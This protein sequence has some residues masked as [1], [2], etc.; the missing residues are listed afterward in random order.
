MGQEIRVAVYA[1]VSTADGRQETENQLGE[2]RRFAESSGWEIV[3][4][5]VDHES[6]SKADR[7]EFRRLFAD[8]ARRQFDI[9]LIWSLDRLSRA[10]VGQNL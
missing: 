10:G 9:L 4:E 7:P 2:L 6:G 5:Y 8:A 1:R 3:G